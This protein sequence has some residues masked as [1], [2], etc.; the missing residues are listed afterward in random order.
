MQN[1]V[2]PFKTCQLTRLHFEAA[3]MFECFTRKLVLLEGHSNSSMVRVLQFSM[4]RIAEQ[5][6]SKIVIAVYV[7]P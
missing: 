3:A 1:V 7:N 4:D 5:H 2:T 6:I